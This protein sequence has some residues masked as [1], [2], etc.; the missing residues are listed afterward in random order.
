MVIFQA[1]LAAVGDREF[2]GE[3]QIYGFDQGF[4]GLFVKQYS[5]FVVDDVFGNAASI[6]GNN[7]FAAGHGF[8]GSEPEVFFLRAN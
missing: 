5:G 6:E 8:N 2:S 7:W 4:G 3:E 1:L